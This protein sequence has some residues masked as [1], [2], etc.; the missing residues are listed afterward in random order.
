MWFTYTPATA[1]RIEAAVQP[2]FFGRDDNFTLSAWTGTPGHLTQ[3][4]C[5]GDELVPAG[6]FMAHVEFDAPIG[7]PIYFMVGNNQGAPG[8]I[9]FFS[10][11]SPLIITPSIDQNGLVAT[12]GLAAVAGTATCNRG[13]TGAS[14]PGTIV[15]QK[16][17][18]TAQATLFGGTS[19]D[20]ATGPAAWSVGTY[21]SNS[22]PFAPGG[23]GNG[24]PRRGL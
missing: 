21:S 14:L 15:Q 3:L 24:R 4:A 17:P 8:D 9:F 20:C 10:M 16:G 12:D 7:Q 1:M 13:E 6:K 23:D 19:A 18:R 5:S 11:Q 22:T 2:E